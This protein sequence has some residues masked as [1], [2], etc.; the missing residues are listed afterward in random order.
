MGVSIKLNGNGLDFTANIT[1]FQ[2]TQIMAFIAQ[3]GED[4]NTPLLSIVPAETELLQGSSTGSAT[5]QNSAYDSPRSAIDS[6]VAKSIPQKIV[7][8]AFYLGAT[9]QNGMVLQFEDVLAEFA[10]AGAAKPTHFPREVKKTVAEGF[11]YLEDKSSFR[12]LSKTDTIPH[13][14]FPKSKHKS[15]T[16]KPKNGNPAEKLVVRPEILDMPITTT[17]DGHEDYFK[18]DKRPDQI[19]WILKYAQ[20]NSFTALNR[21]E[22]LAISSKLGGVFNTGNFAGANQPNVTNGYITL[23]GSLIS[24]SAKGEKHF[25]EIAKAK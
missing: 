10:K 4:A 14:G 12:L 6:L 2:A 16:S 7:A 15:A 19:L 17:M 1:L 13:D 5:V 3:Q 8:I 20:V 24:M 25:A 11:I 9:S 23:T 18:I 21:R 22:V